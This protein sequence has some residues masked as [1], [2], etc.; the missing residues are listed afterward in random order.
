M[1]TAAVTITGNVED[2]ASGSVSGGTIGLPLVHAGYAGSIAAASSATV[3]NASG[4]RANLMTLGA[5][6]SGNVAI[7]NVSGIVP[8]G[9]AAIGATLSNGQPV[10]AINQSFTL[11]Y[12]DN[13]GLPGASDNL[14][15]LAITVTGNVYSGKAEWNGT[16]GL[17]GTAANWK[18]TV[19]GGP[20]G[21]PGV[22][23]YVTDTATF[24]SAIS[25]GVAVVALDSVA[26]LLSDLIFSNSNASYTILQGTG[27]TELTL[28]GTTAGSPAAVTVVSGTHTVAV[29]ILLAS[30]LDVSTSGS[31][32]LNGNLNDGGLGKSLNLDG[33][34]TLILSGSDGYS[35]GTFVQCGHARRDQ[36]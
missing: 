35:G 5:T 34:G 2:H 13:S 12:A 36:R 26:P 3:S 7:N 33:G 6:A 11:D 18:D 28:T 31:L 24:G 30:N 1:G 32:S 9:S 22:S 8:G 16:S 14:G 21:V 29:P 10:G 23:G 19:G 20:S 15:S 4:D 25:S 17:W 27:T